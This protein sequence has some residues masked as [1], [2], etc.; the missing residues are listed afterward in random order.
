[1]L[2]SVMAADD[3]PAR[4][5]T[6]LDDAFPVLV[7]IHGGLVYGIGLRVT[8][9]PSDAEEVAQDALVKAHRALAAWPAERVRAIRLRPWLATVA[10]NAARNHIRRH[11]VTTVSIDPQ[12][13]DV[14][15]PTGDGPEARAERRH[16]ADRLGAAVAA[17]PDAYRAAVVLRLVEGLSYVDVAAALEQPVGTVKANVHRGTKLLRAALGGRND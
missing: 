17:L 4:L 1:V 12:S 2:L 14:A 8:G 16:D 6:D 11:G 10:L 7:R 13:P 9:R 15:A 3:L 5:A